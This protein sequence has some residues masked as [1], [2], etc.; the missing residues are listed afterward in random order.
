MIA[1]FQLLFM[2]EYRAL[3]DECSKKEKGNHYFRMNR[4]KQYGGFAAGG[5]GIFYV[6]SVRRQNRD[7]HLP[8][9]GIQEMRL[10]FLKEHA[11]RYDEILFH[12][13]VGE[14]IIVNDRKPFGL[15]T[16]VAVNVYRSDFKHPAIRRDKEL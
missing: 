4:E 1:D 10:Q 15:K 11:I 9:R 2:E 3:L 7:F 8:H 16:A 13:P 12:M 5:E 6:D 14:R